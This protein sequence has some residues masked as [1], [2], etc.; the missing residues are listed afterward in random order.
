[1]WRCTGGVRFL[2][3]Y[4]STILANFIPIGYPYQCAYL[5]F[6]LLSCLVEQVR[7]LVDSCCCLS[8]ILLCLLHLR[9]VVS[10][11]LQSCQLLYSTSDCVTSPQTALER[12]DT[13]VQPAAVRGEKATY[14]QPCEFPRSNRSLIPTTDIKNEESSRKTD[15]WKSAH[16]S[17]SMSD[18]SLCAMLRHHEGSY[19]P[20]FRFKSTSNVFCQLDRSRWQHY[21]I[22][23]PCSI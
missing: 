15:I 12:W 19:T 3:R 18:I 21:S 7:Y 9:S 4:F 10:L 20:Q 6:L 23:F 2:L 5:T 14:F 22:F 11:I 17:S 8:S 16:Q 1:M 13:E